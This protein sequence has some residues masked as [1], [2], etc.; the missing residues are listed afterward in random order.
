MSR[1]RPYGSFEEAYFNFLFFKKD[2]KDTVERLL[3]QMKGFKVLE[4]DMHLPWTF[5]KDKEIHPLWSSMCRMFG[6]QEP[7]IFACYIP[8]I[9]L[10]MAI[11]WLENEIKEFEDD[12]Y[13][14]A[15]N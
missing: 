6:E 5:E 8:N 1:L 15:S 11:E 7:E 4:A 10:E 3:T 2:R 9:Y 13:E 12:I 14:N